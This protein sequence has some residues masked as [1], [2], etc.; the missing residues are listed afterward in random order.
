[1]SKAPGSLGAFI[2]T[3]VG[4][5]Q[6]DPSIKEELSMEGRRSSTF[7]VYLE[8]VIKP[9]RVQYVKTGG[10]GANSPEAEATKSNRSRAMSANEG[11]GRWR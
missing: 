3:T 2:P 6:F 4:V 10:G 7:K 9:F 11:E 1:M 8:Q 5:V